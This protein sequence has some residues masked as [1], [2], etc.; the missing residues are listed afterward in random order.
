M[1]MQEEIECLSAIYGD[2]NVHF[3]AGAKIV[4]IEIT[5]ST[6][7]QNGMMKSVSLTLQLD[8]AYPAE[9]PTKI[10]VRFDPPIPQSF[11]IRSEDFVRQCVEP[12]VGEPY[13]M[14]AAM[15]LQE[16]LTDNTDK[17]NARDVELKKDSVATESWIVV[18][19]LDHMRNRQKYLKQLKKWCGELGVGASVFI[20]RDVKYVIV[21]VGEK[22]CVDQYLV[23]WKTQCV[24]VDS[25]G[26]PCK[27]KLMTIL[28][29][30]TCRESD[31]ISLTYALHESSDVVDFEKCFSTWGIG[32][33]Y[34][35][36]FS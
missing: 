30:R 24:D 21:L 6:E 17:L 20:L 11:V 15:A 19:K 32:K 7:N 34:V 1:M 2:E 18:L 26:K 5:Q 13:L 16:F 25:K 3:D 10:T 27:E 35:P 9:R 29:S 22:G 28:I 23:N 12:R 4:K 8:A 31:N 33:E 36:L 14:D